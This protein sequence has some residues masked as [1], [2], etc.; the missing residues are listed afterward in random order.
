M[1]LIEIL[2]VV[3]LIASM[4]TLAMIGLG[5]VG[6]SDVQGSALKFS[7]MIRY[8]FNM[9]ATTNQTLQLKLDFETSTFTIERLDVFGGLS[10]EALR[11]DTLKSVQ[12]GSLSKKESR[13]SRLDD[14]D[15]RFGTVN[16]T[17]VEDILLSEDN[18]KLDDEVYFVGLM[19]SHH[20]EMQTDGVGTINFFANGFVEKSIIYLGDEQ[21]R[22]GADDGI[23][24]SIIVNPLTGQSSV[25]PGKQEISS[26]FFE[27]EED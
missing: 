15:S 3:V 25:I 5:I 23:Y 4:M 17:P 10:E 19:T 13:A 14:E 24:Y 11:G 18:T 7:S 8:T 9:A 20:D 22:D 26:T 1:T 21:A 16:R 6:R 2:I 12:S 27:A